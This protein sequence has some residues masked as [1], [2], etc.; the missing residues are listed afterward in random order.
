MLVPTVHNL[1]QGSF[2]LAIRTI[3]LERVE[4]ERKKQGERERE[5]NREREW[6]TT[7]VGELCSRPCYSMAG[8]AQQADESLFVFIGLYRQCGL[9]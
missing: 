2:T 7:G 5:R 3:Y 9:G 8:G 4:R 1:K 6:K